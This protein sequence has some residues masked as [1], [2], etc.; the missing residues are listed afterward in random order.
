MQ[1]GKSGPRRLPDRILRTLCRAS[2]GK[3]PDTGEPEPNPRAQCISAA[4]H[5]C[6]NDGEMMELMREGV[7][8]PIYKKGCRDRLENYR[9]ITVLS[10]LYKIYTKCLV[11]RM[12]AVLPHLIDSAQGAFQDKYV[13]ELARVVQDLSS[14]LESEDGGGLMLFCDQAKAYDRVDWDFMFSVLET[15]EL[16]DDF[17]AMVKLAYTNNRSRVKIN[18]HCGK[19][20]EPSNGVKQG[21]ALSC[22]L[23][24]CVFQA[25]LS[26][27]K[28]PDENGEVLKGIKIPGAL[29]RIEL[30]AH[31][32]ANE[33]I[34]R[35]QSRTTPTTHTAT[36]SDS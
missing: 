35:C 30:R 1:K 10:T 9:P 2:P 31:A 6:I 3:E 24:I 27:L 28:Q 17:I 14:Y 16:G 26:L 34:L 12:R 5:E 11:E 4:R 19:P 8:T 21:C 18:G 22:F 23:Y 25:F 13:G 36:H 32:F 15:M 7:I 29:R 33:H 20:F